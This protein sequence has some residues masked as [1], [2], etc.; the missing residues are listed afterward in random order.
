MGNNIELF[1]S[2]IDETLT[3]SEKSAFE[4]RL[5]EDKA[6]ASDF[7]LYLFVLEGIYKE[8]EQDNME[9]GAA[10]KNISREKLKR[11]LL[12]TKFHGIRLERACRMVTDEE[13]L[14]LGA[15]CDEDLTD[16]YDD[17]EVPES[18]KEGIRVAYSPQKKGK[19]RFRNLLWT[20]SIAAM[21]IIGLFTVFTVHRTQMD[22]MDDTIV[23]YNEIPTSDRGSAE[24]RS[25]D[26]ASL[27][28]A[29][30]NAAPDDMQQGE[31]AGMRL[32]LAYLKAHDR[33]K[34]KV[35]LEELSERYAEDEEFAA[36]CRR[37]LKQLE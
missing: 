23:A 29:Y 21:F 35:L 28:H 30:N 8:N 4:Q 33:K 1:D 7:R 15:S 16:E 2:Y 17:E 13:N 14:C 22:R 36:Q 3:P 37:I 24:N 26:I 34:A 19:K 20:G 9:F 27:E 31:E 5:K 12:P 18:Y 10:L 6:F 25:A 32:A 11:V